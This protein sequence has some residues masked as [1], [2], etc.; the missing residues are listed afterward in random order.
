MEDLADEFVTEH[1]SCK[2]MAANSAASSSRV[3]K[4]IAD[5]FTR[6]TPSTVK[7]DA[8]T[9]SQIKP[10]NCRLDELCKQRVSL[11]L[12]KILG[13]TSTAA[14]QKQIPRTTCVPTEPVVYGRENDRAKILHMVLRAE[15][16]DDSNFHMIP[17]VGMEGIGKTTLARPMCR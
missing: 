15:P 6:L 14:T 2:I 17:I 12:Q 16:T 7:F 1:L 13:G 5:R 9:N 10:I 3:K 8:D 4:I 11:G